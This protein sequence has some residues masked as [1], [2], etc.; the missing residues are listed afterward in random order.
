MYIMC[1]VCTYVFLSC[2]VT[3]R[4]PIPPANGN[5]AVQKK[6]HLPNDVLSFTCEDDFMANGNSLLT[7]MSDG[8]W[9]GNQPLCIGEWVC[10]LPNMTVWQSHER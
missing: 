3:C 2:T 6:W 1:T 8:N 5:F 10:A 9:N 7:C 4:H